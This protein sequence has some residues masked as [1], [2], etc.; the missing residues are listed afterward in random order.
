LEPA[1]KVENLGKEFVIG[2]PLYPENFRE[3][4]ARFFLSPLH[5]YRQL[6]GQVSGEERFTALEG[7]SFEVPQGE[8]LGLIGPNGAGKSTLLKILSKITPPTIGR[9]EILG[10][11]G[12]LLEVG[13]GFNHELT[14]RENIYLNGAILGMRRKEINAQLD[15]IVDFSGV[16]QFLDT[17]VKRYSSGMF[18]RLAFA[19]AAHLRVDILLV[20]E[21]LSVGD[22]EFQRKC[23]GKMG[24]VAQD[25]RT[26][27]LVS[28]NMAAIQNL[29]HRVLLLENGKLSKE[30]SAQEVI[31]TYLREVGEVK[32][33]QSL[34]DKPRSSR[35]TPVL[36]ELRCI[37]AQ[38]V[39]TQGILAGASLE[40]RLK[41]SHHDVLKSPYFG[42]T[43]E[44][45]MGARIFTVQTAQNHGTVPSLSAA[46]EVVCH[47][48][49]VPLAPGSYTISIG[50]GAQG[51]TLDVLERAIP[52]EVHKADVFGTG[53]IL[54]TLHSMVLVDSKWS[55]DEDRKREPSE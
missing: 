10:T 48:P 44:N 31:E 17:P 13:T 40:L 25:G 20:D 37:D 32:P 50:C 39:E 8:V 24:E 9:V 49:K 2:G 5:R 7:V 12:S 18:V 28:H 53:F 11:M 43:F 16:E 21:V 51:Q 46:G 29:C 34:A 4:L 35:H 33:V 38:G 47:I 52:L 3:R 14:G 54:P 15:A 55:F 23:L 19:V 27:I 6:S 42:F 30:G 26:V 22:Q 41:Y 36:Q 45:R 1:I